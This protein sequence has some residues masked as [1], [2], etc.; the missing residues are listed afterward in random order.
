MFVKQ[1]PLG[2]AKKRRNTNTQHFAPAGIWNTSRLRY[3]FIL[4]FVQENGRNGLVVPLPRVFSTLTQ[5]VL[6]PTSCR[7]GRRCANRL[8]SATLCVLS[9][10]LA[11]P[12]RGAGEGWRAAI[13]RYKIAPPVCTKSTSGGSRDG[14]GL[15]GASGFGP[16]GKKSTVSSLKAPSALS[17][18]TPGDG[19]RDGQQRLCDCIAEDMATWESS[20]Q[21]M[22][23]CY[24]P[25]TGKPNV[26]GFP[27]F[28]P[29]EVRLEYYNCSAKEITGYYI[30]AVNQYVQQWRN[31]LQEL[32]AL[33]ASRKASMVSN[34][35]TQPLPSLGLR[36]Q[37]APSSGFPSL[38]VN[39]SSGAARLSSKAKPSVPSGSPPALGSS[40]AASNPPALGVMSS[41]SDPHPVGTGDSSAPSA[42]PFSLHASGTTAA[43]ATSHSGASSASAAQTAGASGHSVTSAPSAFPHGIRPGQLHTPRSEL[44]AEELEQFKAKK[45]TLGKVPLKPSPADLLHDKDLS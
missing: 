21:W 15:A 2:K 37:Q 26:S 11:G 30:N 23:S 39:S 6:V 7:L 10:A 17:S 35:V 20:G 4:V 14:G 13:Q 12:V 18:A 31:K 45:F 44:T 24:S 41:H 25:V 16:A 19:H 1:D 8:P 5:C 42:A 27:E 34:A 28:S 29:E 40:A 3:L 9:S 36:G 38:P 32:K 22:F 43:T 33:N